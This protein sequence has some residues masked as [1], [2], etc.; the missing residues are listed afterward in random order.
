MTAQQ[1][2]LDYLIGEA[3][4]SYGG[5]SSTTTAIANAING[6][7]YN[8][9]WDNVSSLANTIVSDIESKYVKGQQVNIYGYSEGGNI[10]LQISRGLNELNI[11]I[12]ILFTVDAADGHVPI[13]RS[14]GAN[15][16]VNFNFIKQPLARFGLG[17]TLILVQV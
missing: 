15:V 10:A 8:V 3:D 14:I 13:D 12:S 16:L 6:T 4:L 2:S 1:G 9:T 17:E 11:P 7:A 5:I